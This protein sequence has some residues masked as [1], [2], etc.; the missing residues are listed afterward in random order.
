MKMIHDIV[1][2]Q[3]AMGMA[4]GSIVEWLVTEGEHIE[5]DAPLVSIETEKVTI[6]VPAPS[7]GFVHIVTE[8]GTTVPVETLIAQIAD[9]QEEY[10]Q[11]S[12]SP[13]KD[14]GVSPAAS[15]YIENPR[16]ALLEP[17]PVKQSLESAGRVRASGLAK[18]LARQEGIS[19][20]D[21]SGTGPGGRIERHDVLLAIEE[22]KSGAGSEPIALSENADASMREKGRVPLTGMRGTLAEHMTQAKT[23]A[24]QTY[25]YFEI[26][27]TDLLLARETMLNSEEA[28]TRISM[29]P[30]YTKALSLAC[31]H[32]PICNATLTG[33][34]IT[35]WENVNVGIAVA[36][37]GKGKYESGLFVPVIKNVEDKNVMQLSG[38]IKEL[39]EKARSGNLN[40]ED[41]INH[42]ITLSSTGGLASPGAWMV[43]TP[44][45]NLPDVLAFQPGTSIKKPVII[46]NQIVV[47]DI[48][49][50]GLTFDHRAVD[51]EPACRFIQE[52]TNLLSNPELV[53]L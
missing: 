38:E 13:P 8:A 14:V 26:D 28:E 44:V 11:L 23:T 16:A 27:I 15:E 42:T 17:S 21:I 30:I 31:Q 43:S 35:I 29:T 37:P 2:P 24:A 22:R 9:T 19:L 51:G 25:I 18:K 36:V 5:Q 41:M 20:S 48:L 4:E 33:D 45:L 46:D 32:V 6:D 50:C 53:L 49:P 10:A 40:R 39:V 47:R 12:E 3:L 1:L 34:E 7:G 52:I